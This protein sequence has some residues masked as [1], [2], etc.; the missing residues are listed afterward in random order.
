MGLHVC[1]YQAQQELYQ[2]KVHLAIADGKAGVEFANQHYTFIVDYGQNMELRVNNKEQ[3]GL[4]F[5]HCSLTNNVALLID[6]ML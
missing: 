2:E 5:Y 4:M 3:L 6:K 1:I